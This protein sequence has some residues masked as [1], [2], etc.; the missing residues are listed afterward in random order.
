MPTVT[1]PVQF[2]ATLQQGGNRKKTGSR[3]IA[4]AW[5]ASYHNKSQ[6][7]GYNTIIVRL[8]GYLE[9]GL[10]NLRLYI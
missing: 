2:V 6:S 8:Y 10:P 5:Q 7:R 4:K 9:Q 1:L 3:R